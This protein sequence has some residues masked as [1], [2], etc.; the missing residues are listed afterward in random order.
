MAARQRMEKKAPEC[1]CRKMKWNCTLHPIPLSHLLA[2]PSVLP[3]SSAAQQRTGSRLC[4]PGDE[5]DI[6]GGSLDQED[7][8]SSSASEEEGEDAEDGVTEGEGEVEG[9]GGV[10]AA[11][12][13]EAVMTGGS[14]K[15]ASAIKVVSTKVR[16]GVNNPGAECQLWAGLKPEMHNFQCVAPRPRCSISRQGSLSPQGSAKER[17]PHVGN[18]GVKGSLCSWAFKNSKPLS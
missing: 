3:R 15:Q 12:E 4:V 17:A 8:G 18:P 16:H 6:P 7:E 5:S 11:G 1:V 9:P 10:E 13:E 2:H 14:A